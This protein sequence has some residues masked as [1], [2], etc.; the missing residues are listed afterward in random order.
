MPQV[1][2]REWK[3]K[4]GT[5]KTSKAYYARFQ[6]NGKEVFRSTGQI[7]KRDAEQEMQR[8]ISG[9]RDGSGIEGLLKRLK[10]AIDDLPDEEQV[11]RRRQVIQELQRGIGHKLALDEVWQTWLDNPNKG[12]PGARTLSGYKGQWDRFNKWAPKQG[13]QYLHETTPAITEQYTA[14]LWKSKMAARTYNSH[15]NLLQSMFKTLRL[16]ASI[17][18]NPWEH[19]I[20]KEAATESKRNFT[21]EELKTVC[22]KAKG[23][24]RYL[25]ALG[26]YTGMRMGDCACLAWDAV[27][28]KSG[29]ISHVP[30]KTMRKGKQVRIPIHPVLESLLLELR[31]TSKGLYL[32]PEERESYQHDGSL[33]S[34]R[35]K[36]FFQ[37]TCEIETQ[38]KST[39]GQRKNVVCRVGFHSLR[40]SFVS[41]CAANRV[42]QVAIM[43]LVGHGSP[44]MTALYSHAGDEQK[45]KAITALPTVSFEGEDLVD[46]EE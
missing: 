20:Q 33:L 15:I 30:M 14:D 35:I 28:F 6:V 42:P 38:D 41:L 43:E 21:P 37:N 39:T 18:D 3:D 24:M 8:M 19:I 40:H 17:E 10:R 34:R 46:S 25:I 31:E 7:K 23:D 45:L 26:L 44:A 16:A 12:N 11:L 27:D 9:V 36:R 5:I 13:I 29:M 4:D 1:F 2:K 32:F 22:A